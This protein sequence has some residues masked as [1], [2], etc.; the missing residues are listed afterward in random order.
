MILTNLV[1]FIT[2]WDEEIGPQLVDVFPKEPLPGI[3]PEIM[4]IQLFMTFEN[5]FGIK[6]NTPFERTNLLIPIPPLN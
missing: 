4:G 2:L 3:D 6:P 5:V 1:S